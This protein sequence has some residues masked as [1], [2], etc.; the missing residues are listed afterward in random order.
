[1]FLMSVTQTA[2]K[3]VRPGNGVWTATCCCCRRDAALRESAA[4]AVLRLEAGSSK[5]R[6]QKL[7]EL[8]HPSASVLSALPSSHLL[9]PSAFVCCVCWREGGG[10]GAFLAASPSSTKHEHLSSSK[11]LFMLPLMF[12]SY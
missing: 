11:H 3:P 10:G 4:P 12:C 6:L 5:P 7:Q 9:P 8:R 1:M 2:V